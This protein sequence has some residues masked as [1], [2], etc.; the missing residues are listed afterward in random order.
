MATFSFNETQ[1]HDLAAQALAEVGKAGASSAAV[2]ISESMGQTVTVR[3]NEVETI[4]YNRD[5]G[6]SITAYV[7]QKKGSASTSDM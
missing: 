5:N 3:L 6:L 1:L 7:G 4:A 2:N